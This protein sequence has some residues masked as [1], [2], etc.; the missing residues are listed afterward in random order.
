MERGESTLRIYL[1]HAATTP[2][3]PA[4]AEKVYE[5]M[6]EGFGNPSSV[7]GLGRRA[8]AAVERARRQVAALIGADPEEILFTSGAT[9]SNNLAI[10]GALRAAGPGSHVV[11][12]AVEHHAVLDV[13]R[14]LGAEGYQVTVVPVDGHGRVDPDDVARAITPR[15]ALV[16]VMLA[17]NEIGTLQPVA[18]I[19][20]I[21]HERGVLVHTDAAQAVGRMPV[22]VRSLDV[23]LLTFSGHKM[24]APKGIGA[25]Y[26]RRGTR[27]RLHPLLHGGGQE[28]RLRPGTENVPAIVGFGQAAEL[29]AA[30]LAER[31]EVERRWR[32]RLIDGLLAAIPGA[33]LNGH[34]TERLPSNVNL[35][36]P[37]VAVDTLLIQLDLEG[38]AASSGSACTAG[39][40]QP[41]HVLM[42]LGL[43]R[44]AAARALRLTV[45]RCNDDEQIEAA[46]EII[47]RV[48]ARLRGAARFAVSRG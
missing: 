13:C 37:D 23:D 1:D 36:I 43:D 28:G 24:Y 30:D 44:D 14:A 41:S 42:A 19:A 27:R 16:S 4:V 12:T 8:R 26:V 20:R 17:N 11:T 46:L 33:S 10:Q 22:D 29:A 2:V 38:I 18:E 6:V 5:A 35:S 32:D 48:V 3:L 9:E 15:T 21:A 7:H 40:I 39:S 31:A 47:P 45:G 34:P 25:L